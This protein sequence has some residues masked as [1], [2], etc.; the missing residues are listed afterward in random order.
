MRG[1]HDWYIEDAPSDV[2]VLNIL[3]QDSGGAEAQVDDASRYRDRYDLTWTLL[4]D[5]QGTWMAEW[6]ALGGASQHS[7]AIV[8]PDGVILWRKADGGSTSVL[9]IETV[10]E[11]NSD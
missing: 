4:A 5:A 3:T 2:V 7:Y 10:L 1:L 6:G 9:E 11:E 8:D